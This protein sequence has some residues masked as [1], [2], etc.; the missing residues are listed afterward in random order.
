MATT[1][2][3]LMILAASCNEDKFLEEKPLSIYSA[4]NSL[5]TSSDFQAAS[6]RLYYNVRY[7][8]RGAVNSWL[9]YWVGTD[10][11]FVSC[12]ENFY[13][14]WEAT[15]VPTYTVIRERYNAP[16]QIVTHANLILSRLEKSSLSDADKRQFRGEALFFRGYA[17]NMLANL[18]GGVPLIVEEISAPRRD[19]VR[20]SREETYTQAKNDLDEAASLLANIDQVKDGKVSKQLA[21]HYLSETYI[22]LG[23]Y[24]KAIA[25]ATAVIDY[26]G[27]RLM[28]TRFGSK[29]NQPGNFYSD[30]HQANNYNRASGNL[31]GLWVLQY[32]YLNPGTFIDTFFNYF[33]P[34]YSNITLT[35]D[36]VTTTAFLG[37]TAEK[38][39]R[40]T[41]WAQPTKWFYEELWQEGDLRNSEYMIVRDALIDNPASP[42]FGKWFVADGYCTQ[43]NRFRQW[44]PFIRKIASE[45]PSNFYRLDANGNPMLTPFGEH[46]TQNTN[47]SFKDAYLVRLADTYLLRAEAYLGKNNKTASAADINI[48]RARVQAPL[49]NAADIDIDYILDERMRELY[50]EELRLC[51]LMRLGKFVERARRY[52]TVYDGPAGTP[53]E[54]SGTS[55]KEYHNLLP[56][57]YDEIER[58][59][60]TKL[61][62]NP[63]YK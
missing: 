31:E 15:M 22:S 42:A 17:Y 32:D 58:N 8:I 55:V 23:D 30:L 59:V 45:V 6:N 33:N 38:G 46:L 24:D 60:L 41:A 27:I 25:A 44:F 63:G 14:K 11:A 48:I 12:D 62:Q 37:N 9:C 16:F 13:N 61:E 36:G 39:G 29:V 19:F 40:S 50:L 56:I 52:N 2:L 47:S 21:Q 53:M 57:P 26:P 35:V 18:F 54:G 10:L 34:F 51:T 1:S 49:A 5:V 4:D 43:S 20:S 28:T 7:M 3:I